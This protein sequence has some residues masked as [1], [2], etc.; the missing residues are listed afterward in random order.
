MIALPSRD[1]F[2]LPLPAQGLDRALSGQGLGT[3]AALLLVDQSDGAP[4]PGVARGLALLV[5]PESA[6]NI[7]GHSG[8]EG[9]VTA[10]E[11]IEEPD[12]SC[13]RVRRRLF[14]LCVHPPEHTSIQRFH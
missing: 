3:G 14:L 9:P 1:E 5:L 7:G 6:V 8:V 2:L 4:G 11:D 10:S 12:G 13:G